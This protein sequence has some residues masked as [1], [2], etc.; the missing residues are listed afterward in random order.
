MRDSFNAFECAG[1]VRRRWKF[2]AASCALAGVL[3]AAISFTLPQRYTAIATLVID[4]P[5]GNDPRAATVVSPIYLES[6]KTYERFAE[7]DSLFV[8]AAGRFQ[9]RNGASTVPVDAL[10]RRVLK[11]TKPRDT[12]L[13]E[14]RVTLADPV[15]AQAVAQFIAQETANLARSVERGS[16][17]EFA[18]GAQTQVEA[19]RARMEKAESAWSQD[20][21][22][23]PTESLQS[24]TGGLTDLKLYIRR[25]L[26][27]A[28]AGRAD[29]EAQ[30]RAASAPETGAPSFELKRI[31]RELAGAVARA[32]SL[33]TELDA[34]GPAIARKEA[35]LAERKGRAELLDAERRAAHRAYDA[36]AKHLNDLRSTEGIRGERLRVIDPGIVPQQPSSP[37]IPLNILSAVLLA[38]LA[39]VLYLTLAFSLSARERGAATR[40]A[41]R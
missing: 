3:A 16:D 36:A 5:A 40:T 32:A 12:K 24:E 21:A 14:I 9:L 7:S 41:Y 13:L 35:V 31:R 37:N 4:A 23:R 30:E 38:A 15:K 28:T 25:Q 34:L 19:G 2:I 1:Y 27:D 17:E 33:K 6:L 11:V 29:L 22:S 26:A 8:K 18:A 20:S 39:S 10:K